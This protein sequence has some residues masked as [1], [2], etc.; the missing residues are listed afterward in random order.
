MIFN[1]IIDEDLNQIIEENNGLRKLYN[2]TVMI[3][4]ASGL[5]GS[6]FLNTLIKLNEEYGANIKI[7]PL[8]RNLN[9]LNKEI[10]N[11]E[12]INP[13]VQDILKPI[14]Y[15]GDVDYIIH[16]ASPASPP[17]MREKPVETNLANTVG[18]ANALTFAKEHKTKKFLF[19][20]SREVYGQN[21]SNQKYFKEDDIGLINQLI[22]RNSY[23]E[24]KKAAENMCLGF[25]EEYGLDTKIVRLGQ[26]F[27]P[28]MNI[29]GGMVHTEFLKMLLNN[30]DIV[31]LSDGSSLRTYT[32]ISDAISAMFKII[33]ESKDI[34][35][36]AVNNKNEISI[37]EL[38]ETLITLC[39][40]KK[41]K[42][43]FDIEEEK[44][45]YDYKTFKFC[46]ITSEK[47]RDELG[48][49]PKYSIKEGFE[50]TINYLNS[51]VAH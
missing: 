33:L 12:Y 40:E 7:I 28:G 41:S 25:N 21:I 10:V 42:L 37:K 3:T 45:G 26:T 8:I 29:N 38:A 44:E 47:I 36:N 46:L 5:I 20:S 39:P 16:A 11:K 35:Y 9:R 48:W 15:D 43:V 32:Y 22:P 49:N 30:E 50:R 4:G 24:S 23:A 6:Y 19:I 34:V 14:K 51:D 2:Q 17:L 1:K 13:I 31:L 27:G 18:T